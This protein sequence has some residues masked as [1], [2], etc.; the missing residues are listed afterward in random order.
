[1]RIRVAIP[2]SSKN[3]PIGKMHLVFSDEGAAFAFTLC[4]APLHRYRLFDLEEEIP[5]AFDKVERCP[6]CA[7]RAGTMNKA[8]GKDPKVTG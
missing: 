5:L 1:M 4:G 3:K 8:L 7:G 2:V 6:R